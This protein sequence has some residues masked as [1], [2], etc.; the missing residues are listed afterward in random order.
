MIKGI[1]NYYHFWLV[2]L[3]SLLL[4]LTTTALGNTGLSLSWASGIFYFPFFPPVVVNSIVLLILVSTFVLL[5]LE[6]QFFWNLKDSNLMN[7]L[8]SSRRF[9]CRFL[10]YWQS[11]HLNIG[12]VLLLHF[13][14]CMT[15]LPL[16][17]W[18]EL[19]AVCIVK[20][21]RMDILSLFLSFGRKD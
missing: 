17:H 13:P 15:F 8:F 14:T 18:L 21:M 5:V 7:S 6:I 19:L 20:A 9:F 10:A 12:T 11:C 3:I 2:A 4:W 1:D 16:F